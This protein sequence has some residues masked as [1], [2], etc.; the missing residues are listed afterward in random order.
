[1]PSVDLY[2]HS[3]NPSPAQLIK[4][5]D[6]LLSK[7][8]FNQN[9]PPAVEF[10]KD[11]EALAEQILGHYQSLS[12]LA[13][14]LR[15]LAHPESKLPYQVLNVFMYAGVREHASFAEI[16]KQ[17]DDLYGDEKDQ[18][19]LAAMSGLTQDNYLMLVPKPSLWGDDGRL[20]Y[21][22]RV[23]RH[24]HRNTYIREV[25]AFFA[26]GDEG[27]RKI[28]AD[29]AQ[30][31]EASRNML[32]ED[33]RK[34]VYRSLMPDD[35]PT[36]WLLRGKLDDVRDG[37]IRFEKLFLCVDHADVKDGFEDRLEHAFSLLESL[38]KHKA[39]EVLKG[40][41]TCIRE[42]M[43]DQS[44]TV[45]NLSDEPDLVVPRLVRVLER[46]RP[47]GFEALP[48]VAKHTLSD[49]KQSPK[50]HIEYILDGGFRDEWGNLG[51]ES[52]WA[53]AAAIACDENYLLSLGLSEKHLAILS[54]QKGTPGLRQ[55][56]QKTDTG[57]EI[58]FGQDLGL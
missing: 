4:V 20:K 40:I 22:P 39:D 19:A 52:A 3:T 50:R 30:M 32:D 16:I 14:E 8:V 23:F 37:L 44:G 18:R 26:K 55:A 57:R 54:A 42:W 24:M 49:T 31:D 48:E 34:R 12:A 21:S 38:D 58:V 7:L 11:A 51:T 15:G 27:V 9:K 1:M 13:G 25:S 10:L 53:E 45:R 33:L 56:L 43:T 46:A 35:H 41:A 6:D 36:R 29:Y 5:C 2:S 28:L 17:L 47:M